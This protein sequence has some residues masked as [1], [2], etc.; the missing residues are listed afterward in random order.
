[1]HILE[2][3]VETFIPV[4]PR[5]RKRLHALGL[6]T[7][8]DLLYH[9]PRR[10]EDYSNIRP[11]ASLKKGETATIQGIITDIQGR[12]A[13]GR[14]RLT[15]IKAAVEDN[16]GTISAVWFNQHYLLKTLLQGTKVSLSGKVGVG[17]KGLY[18]QHPEHEIINEKHGVYSIEQDSN[19]HAISHTPQ[20][21]LRHTGRLVPI[22][23]ETR[24]MTSRWFR[25][26]IQQALHKLPAT[27]PDIIPANIREREHLPD[28]ANSLHEIHLPRTEAE[29]AH[30]RER[31]RFE[32]LFLLQIKKYQTILELRAKKAPA[33]PVDRA[34]QEHLLKQIPFPLTRAQ[35]AALSDILADIERPNPMN[36]LVNGD[37]G[38][39]K[40][41]VAFLAALAAIRSGYQVAFMAPTEI[42][43]RQH[44]Q[45]MQAFFKGENI[46]IGLATSSEK[47]IVTPIGNSE[48]AD[49]AKLARS[50]DLEL[51]IGTHALIQNSMAFKNLGLIIVDEQHRFGVAQRAKLLAHRTNSEYIPHFLSMT[52]TPIPRTLALTV[53]GDLDISVIGEM[54]P[55]RKTV[56]TKIV[57]PTRR[58]AAYAFVEEEIKKGRQA[59][60]ICPRIEASES[61]EEHAHHSTA[62]M[63]AEEMKSV[64]KEFKKLSEE[65]FLHRRIAIVHGKMKPKEKDE[66]V[67]GFKSG[68]YDVLVATSVIEVGIDIPN[69]TVMM[70]ESAEQFGLAALHQFRGRVGRGEH[71]SYCLLFP[72]SESHEENGRLKAVALSKNGFELA[73]KDLK[74][75]GPG[76]LVGLDQS[77][78][79]ASLQESLMDAALVEKTSKAAKKIIESDPKLKKYPLLSERI[80]S[81]AYTLHAE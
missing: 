52:A 11:I 35:R 53:Y 41:L 72:T 13:W 36:R 6:K 65:V 55:G 25:F 4:Q 60:V 58:A 54:P 15:I 2:T 74:L 44:F 17:K 1:M 16:S 3:P 32:E 73:E 28:F 71:Q 23:P 47:K 26:L 70:I 45:T 42:L 29:A 66:V 9:F 63:L 78:F 77:G 27:I 79:H 20:A 30:A 33:I 34:Y 38:S 24:G 19:L 62:L 50:G 14:R 22:Y 61:P 57:R 18:L 5:A 21:T 49:V 10:Y 31:F 69:A 48:K 75:R 51:V 37:V 12:H 56:I 59:F 76:N 39:G 40:T 80:S 7:V 43:A 64:K 67:R 46:A 68:A 81:V 8:R